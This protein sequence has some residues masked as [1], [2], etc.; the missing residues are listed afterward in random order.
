MRDVAVDKQCNF[1]VYMKSFFTKASVLS[2]TLG[3]CLSAFSAQAT[4]FKVAMIQ[5]DPWTIPD[6]VRPGYLMGIVPDLM[7]EI[8]KRTGHKVTGRMTPYARVEADLENGLVDFSFMAWGP[9]RSKYANKGAAGFTLEFGVWAVKGVS[10]KNYADLKGKTISVTRGLKVEPYFDADTTLDKEPDLDYTVGVKKAKLGRVQAVAGSL[11][12]I[13]HVI[14]GMSAQNSFGDIL[15]LTST[16]ATISYSKKS[17]NI[18][19]EN[20]INNTVRQ[21][22]ADGTMKKIQEKWLKN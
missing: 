8:E 6:P 1:G 3:L 9:Q 4:E 12:T 18:A 10:I 13:K 20:L 15:V 19:H 5:L 17:P 2:L 7:R 11:S 21:I 22:V 16:E 14:A